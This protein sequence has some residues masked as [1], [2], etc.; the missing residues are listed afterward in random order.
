MTRARLLLVLLVPALG[1]D[2][3]VGVHDLLVVD[4]DDAAPGPADATGPTPGLVDTGPAPDAPQERRTDDGPLDSADGAADATVSG[5]DASDDDAGDDAGDA[6]DA[7]GDATDGEGDADA[8]GDTDGGSDAASE[9]GSG[10]DGAAAD[11]AA[12][13]GDDSG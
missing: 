12:G 6:S 9:V 10:P 3:L 11:G 8:Q 1:C 2:A 4:S 5:L 13:D 7:A